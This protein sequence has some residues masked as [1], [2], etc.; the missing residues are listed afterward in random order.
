MKK[1]V[2]FSFILGEKPFSCDSCSYTTADHNSMR[3]HKLR[4]TGEKP[5]K[6]IHCDYACIQS[7][8]YKVHLKT[9]HP[10]LEKDLLYSCPDCAFRSI[11]KDVFSAHLLTAH[12]LK[13]T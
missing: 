6:C 11:N 5:Y 1:I 8:T 10:G 7:S 2:F 9:K 13:S 12:K 4:H 3:R